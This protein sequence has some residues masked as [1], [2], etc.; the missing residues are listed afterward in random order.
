MKIVLTQDELGEI[1][2]AHY[3]PP[4]NYRIRGVD[5]SKYSHDFCTIE[6]EPE[7]TAAP[8]VPASEAPGNG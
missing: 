1:I 6:F 5:V 7:P 4:P 3:P 8:I 2:R